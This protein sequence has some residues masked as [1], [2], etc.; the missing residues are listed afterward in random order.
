MN[1]IVGKVCKEE[2]WGD[3]YKYLGTLKEAWVDIHTD[4]EVAIRT[5]RHIE[6][7]ER[8]T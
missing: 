4:N 8:Q 7:W 1:E 6:K 5:E 3:K 2:I